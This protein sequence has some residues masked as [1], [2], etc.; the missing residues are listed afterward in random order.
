ML[1]ID[2]SF[3]DVLGYKEEEEER[4]TQSDL[5]RMPRYQARKEFTNDPSI[6][7]HR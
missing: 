7:R 4:L 2:K 5:N 1:V 6:R 3:K